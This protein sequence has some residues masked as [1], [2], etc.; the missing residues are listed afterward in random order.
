MVTLRKMLFLF[1]RFVCF[2]KEMMYFNFVYKVNSELI[3]V[4]ALLTRFVG[5]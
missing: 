4:V 3:I 1:L 2:Y 5:D